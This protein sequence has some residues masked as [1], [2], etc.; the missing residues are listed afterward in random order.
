M[1]R[2]VPRTRESQ[3]VGGEEQRDAPLG[4]TYKAA[5]SDQ[6]PKT[7]KSHGGFTGFVE[8]WSRLSQWSP[9]RS[10]PDLMLWHFPVLLKTGSLT[11]GPLSP[12]SL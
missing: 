3:R 6:A 5:R 1:L 9:A 10:R 12:A 11:N 4:F 2:A 7:A 8:L